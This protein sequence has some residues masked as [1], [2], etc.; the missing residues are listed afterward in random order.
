MPGGG[1]VLDPF[2][3]SFSTEAA[4]DSLG[5]ECTSIEWGEEFAMPDDQTRVV[6]RPLRVARVSMKK[7]LC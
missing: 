3:G 6:F 4:C 5:L 2:A 7:R 1:R